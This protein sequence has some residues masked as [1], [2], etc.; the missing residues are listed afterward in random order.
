MEGVFE[1]GILDNLPKIV[2]L[3][4]IERCAMPVNDILA[5][6]N[7][8]I[9]HKGKNVV[10]CGFVDRG[11]VKND[12]WD[13][14][15]FVKLREKVIGRSVKISADVFSALP[16]FIDGIADPKI[17]VWFQEHKCVVEEIFIACSKD[18]LRVLRQCL[19]DCSRVLS[20]LDDDIMKST[21]S[22]LRFVKT[23][24]PLSLAV[25]LGRISVADLADRNNYHSVVA[26]NDGESQH[27][28]FIVFK[29]YKQAEIYD[30]SGTSVLPRDL[31]VALI[32]DGYAEPALINS[33]LRATGQFSGKPDIH[34]WRRLIDWRTVKSN[35]MAT[36]YDE[37]L[38]YVLNEEQIEAGPY[39]HIANDLLTILEKAG[40]DPLT[41]QKSIIE[42][43]GT[44]SKN[45]K[46]PPALYGVNFGWDMRL[47]FAFGGYTFD[48]SPSVAQ[49]IETMKAAQLLSF[50]LMKKD[51]GKRLLDL[52]VSDLDEFRSEFFSSQR[53]SSYYETEILHEIDEPLFAKSVLD[54]L[55][56]GRSQFIAP[57]V[58]DL[59]VRCC[60]RSDQFT[61]EI[62][63][64]LNVR[65]L[66]IDFS[67][68]QHIVNQAKLNSFLKS[69][70][71]FSHENKA[72]H[73][74]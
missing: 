62:D 49:V 68:S 40:E 20:V 15:S 30:S 23:F 13:K 34:I 73:S 56:G 59:S 70:W 26:P 36:V 1:G 16:H 28:L 24:L 21:D 7:F 39:L 2:I 17:K 18:N 52:F 35:D 66:M 47:G 44:L 67:S 8:L 63:W 64:A 58:R 61:K 25:A 5:I 37:A 50:D 19:H 14:D 74:I 57:L 33:I 53:D 46:I 29:E 12:A 10:I 71:S 42:R 32:G 43:I 4:D 55:Y 45:R 11:A 6:I 60:Q 41:L 31:G 72:A 27:P 38:S 3:D 69:C 51:E 65:N 48:P 54:H 22:I 9:E